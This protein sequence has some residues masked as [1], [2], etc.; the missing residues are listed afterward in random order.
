[1]SAPHDPVA[2]A[3]AVAQ[4]LDADDFDAAR[5]HLDEACEYTIGESRLVGPDAILASYAE[6][7]RRAHA[8]FEAVRYRSEPG[9]ADG[10]TVTMHYVDELEFGGERHVH[11][12]RQH[13]TIGPGGRVVRIV[14]EEIPGEHDALVAFVER[15]GIVL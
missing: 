7:T 11:Q 3:A 14:H 4:A 9:A 6:N 2:I 15:H 13:L 1:M 12:C 10:A 5:L 8:A